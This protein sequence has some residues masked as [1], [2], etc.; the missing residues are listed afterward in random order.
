M[1]DKGEASVT[2]QLE[3]AQLSHYE[4]GRRCQYDKSMTCF[5]FASLTLRQKLE[6]KIRH[7]AKEPT[8]G[9]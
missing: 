7:L 2:K 8:S 6:R 1:K 5:D 4:C 3:A 9:A